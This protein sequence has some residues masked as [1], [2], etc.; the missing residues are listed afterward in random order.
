MRNNS[1][2]CYSRRRFLRPGHCLFHKD[3]SDS[4]PVDFAA[5]EAGRFQKKN[6]DRM[7]NRED[8]ALVAGNDRLV[9]R[10]LVVAVD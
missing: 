5:A 9:V 10:N 4:L 7:D 1:L 3:D 6:L 2:D 8:V